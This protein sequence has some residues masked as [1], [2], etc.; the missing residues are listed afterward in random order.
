MLL[1][2]HLLVQVEQVVEVMVLYGLVL[3]KQVEPIL[4]VAVEE[5]IEE[6]IM[7]QAVKV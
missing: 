3:H 6:L 2:A 7:E 5:T 1:K 4:V